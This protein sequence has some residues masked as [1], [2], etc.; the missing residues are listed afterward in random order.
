MTR[1]PVRLQ[2][3]RK[4]GFRL[5]KLSRATN[6]LAAVNCARPS[7][8]GNRW[9][10]GDFVTPTAKIAVEQFVRH[11]LPRLKAQGLDDLRGKNLACWCALDARW[12]HVD[13]LLQAANVPQ[14]RKVKR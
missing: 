11:E 12:C 2:L 8:R 1:K 3:S 4:K 5:Q 13:V 9:R 7:K 10:V 14:K 6:G